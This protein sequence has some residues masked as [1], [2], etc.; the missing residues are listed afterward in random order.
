MKK[1]EI[2]ENIRKQHENDLESLIEFLESVI[3]DDE[4]DIGSLNE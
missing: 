2:I 4:V 3:P 1:K